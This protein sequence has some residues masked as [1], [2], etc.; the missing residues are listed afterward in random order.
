M[1]SARFIP[2]RY[3]GGAAAP[4]CRALKNLAARLNFKTLLIEQ[5]LT[6][7]GICVADRADYFLSLSLSVVSL[8]IIHAY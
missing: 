6:R 8:D 7:N 3:L 1:K 2:T 4:L 5:S